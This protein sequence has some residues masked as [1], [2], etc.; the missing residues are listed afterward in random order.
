MMMFKEEERGRAKE[1]KKGD[2]KRA[3]V[4]GQKKKFFIEMFHDECGNYRSLQWSIIARQ[5]VYV[6]NI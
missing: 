4:E 1:R 3:G 6:R 2:E 5:K